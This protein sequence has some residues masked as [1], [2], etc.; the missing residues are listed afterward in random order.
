MLSQRV[1]YVLVTLC[2]LLIYREI[3]RL[4]DPVYVEIICG[5]IKVDLCIKKL[6][7]AATG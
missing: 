7:K 6:V 2:N 1:F 3:L 4:C 5:Q